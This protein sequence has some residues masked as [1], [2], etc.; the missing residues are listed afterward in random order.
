MYEW[1]KNLILSSE[2]K[3]STLLWQAI[4]K[5]ASERNHV[6][7]GKWDFFENL[8]QLDWFNEIDSK[9]MFV[10]ILFFHKI[11]HEQDFVEKGVPNDCRRE[12][13]G[14]FMD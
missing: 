2:E 5:W 11:L 14:T 8:F 6:K 4:I 13:E 3:N 10:E 1:E 7:R 12:L 9:E